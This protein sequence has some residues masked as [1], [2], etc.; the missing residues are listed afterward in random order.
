VAFPPQIT[1]VLFFR[2]TL[3][4]TA[5]DL[6]ISSSAFSNVGLSE[7]LSLMTNS[8]WLQLS[9]LD[10]NIKMK[11]ANVKFLPGVLWGFCFIILIGYIEA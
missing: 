6:L 3:L 10:Q 4:G 9:I 11:N 7:I 1:Q 5:K 2:A 8:S